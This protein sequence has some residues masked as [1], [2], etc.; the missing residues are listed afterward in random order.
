MKKNPQTDSTRLITGGLLLIIIITTLLPGSAAAQ[1]YPLSP[2]RSPAEVK[3][4]ANHL[5]CSRDYLRASFEY[6]SLPAEDSINFRLAYCYLKTRNE[7]KFSELYPKL[8]SAGLRRPLAL[9][10][11]TDKF[12]E[13][14]YKEI[15]SEYRSGRFSE[16][17]KDILPLY[18]ASCF[19]NDAERDADGLNM[20]PP[21]LLDSLTYYINLKSK[22]VYHPIIAACI[23]AVLPGAGKIYTGRYEEGISAFL[24]TGL[25]AYVTAENIKHDHKLRAWVTGSFAA[26]FYSGSVY[27]SY[28]SAEVGNNEYRAGVKKAF[29]SFFSENGHFTESRGTDLCP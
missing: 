27:G 26:F 8:N 3:K 21:V 29:S 23:S 16:F 25:L 10:R 9:L 24:L 5:F 4:F 1:S 13:E 14:K 2:F 22:T 28:V 15:S 17:G 20:L 7:D 19:M 18:A 6:E 11:L 12:D